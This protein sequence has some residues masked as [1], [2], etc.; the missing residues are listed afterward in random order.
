MLQAG[1][2]NWSAESRRAGRLR[3]SAAARKVSAE[4]LRLAPK[5]IELLFSARI[6]LTFIDV[7]GFPG[8]LHALLER[9]GLRLDVLSPA[10]RRHALAM[11][12]EARSTTA[13]SERMTDLVLFLKD[14]RKGDVT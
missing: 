2:P 6:G 10:D 14:R 5:G 9:E 1:G 13:I 12:R 7:T 4:D 8:P 3:E 11:I